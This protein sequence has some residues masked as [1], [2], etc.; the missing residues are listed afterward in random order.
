[1][2]PADTGA[3]AVV[4][5]APTALT[6]APAPDPAPVAPPVGAS[7]PGADRDERDQQDDRLRAGTRAYRRANLALFAAGLATFALLYSTQ[8]LL[9]ALS[10]GLRLSPAQA[11]LTVSASTGALALTLLPASALSEK[12]GR[13]RV[14]TVSVFAA[15][16]LALAVPFAPD[17][18]VLVTLRA[19][20][21]VALAGLPATAMAYLAEE[22]H[23][24]AVPSAIGLYVAG[25][26]IG[27]MSSRVA[28]GAL[29]QVYGWRTALLVVGATALACAVAFRVL[30]PPARHFTPGSISPAALRRTVAGHLRDGRLRRLYAV[31]MLF[32]AVFGA[33]YTVLGY[34][35]TSAP[36]T[37]SQSAVG[38]VFLVYLVGTGTS[39]ASGALTAR[40]GRR[41]AF[42]VALALCAG[43]LA[44]TLARPLWAVL[45]GLVLITGGFFIGHAVASGAVSRTARSGRAQASALYLTA[46]YVGN[47]LGG[48]VAASAYHLSGWAAAAAVAFLALLL[49]APAALRRA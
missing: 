5:P 4:R 15:S 14:M 21:G 35:L 20:Q 28:G 23:P 43:G 25:N 31:G 6:P 1:M 3:G 18:A 2:D 37:L 13:T 16:L 24:S 44:V 42:A 26:S 19:L 39:A 7:G 34:R 49:A 48:T 22:V 36:Y 33:V 12:Y 41:G 30:A 9:P 38:A 8:A 10:A 47:S 29:A 32:M 45:L 11:S 17:L 27:G 40:V 46:Y